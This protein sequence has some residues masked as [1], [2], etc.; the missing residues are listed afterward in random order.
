MGRSAWVAAFLLLAFAKEQVGEI[1]EIGV[2]GLSQGPW[3]CVFFSFCSAFF[4]M[5][6]RFFVLF[7]GAFPNMDFRGPFGVPLNPPQKRGY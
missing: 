2:T 5:G 1:G 6:L 3:C 4:D 7:L